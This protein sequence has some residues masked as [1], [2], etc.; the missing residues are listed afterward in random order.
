MTRHLFLGDIAAWALGVGGDETALSG[1]AGKHA[2]VIPGGVVA[3]YTA[4]TGGT[5]ITDLQ[6]VLGNPITSVTADSDGALPQIQGPDTTP[7]TWWMWA[8]GNAGAGPRVIV[9]ATD[10]G[11]T[12]TA[13]TDAIDDLITSVSALQTAAG[14]SLGVL[15]KDPDT[16]DWP[17]RPTDSRPY[18][19]IGDSAPP[20]GGDYA[21][22]GRDIWFN[23]NPVA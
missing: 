4:R 15:V 13:D 7:D 8:D 11:S 21:V 17:T 5:Q 23:Q 10:M 18:M 12:V 9:S 2:L 16:G 20:V 6:D 14:N 3:F 19:W 1:V 22:A